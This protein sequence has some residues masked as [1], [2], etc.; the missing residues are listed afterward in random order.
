MKVLVTGAAGLIGSHLCR[1]LVSDGHHVIGLVHN[2]GSPML[3][4]IDSSNLELRKCDIR[5]AQAVDKIIRGG[6]VRTVFHL[7]AHLPHTANPDFIGVN[8]RGTINLRE[9]CRNNGVTEFIFASSMS[10]YSAPPMYLPVDEKHPVVPTDEYGASKLTGELLCTPRSKG[11]PRVIVLRYASVFGNGDNSRAA[12]NFMA[13]ALSGRPISVDGDGSQS[14]DFI[15]VDDA[16]EGTMLAW[17]KGVSGE[18]YNIGSGQE[19]SILEMATLI[20]GLPNPATGVEMSG[21]PAT[22]SFRFV[23]DIRKAR[24]E[25][26]YEPKPLIQG[27]QS[28]WENR[29]DKG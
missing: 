17:E 10:V 6:D 7:A 21:K 9:A 3:S 29:H 1:R 16:V 5:D 11:I 22:R 18:V 15:Y 19:I 23:A 24:R 12:F 8:I 13:A 27:L 25:L 28:Y 14:S 2:T 20:S 4:S 26:G